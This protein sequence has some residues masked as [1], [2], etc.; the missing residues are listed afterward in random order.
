MATQLPGSKT[1]TVESLPEAATLDVP[2]ITSDVSPTQ[3]APQGTPTGERTFSLGTLTKRAPT[4]KKEPE[5]EPD[6]DVRLKAA[7]E[8]QLQGLKNKARLK[9]AQGNQLRQ[10]KKKAYFSELNAIKGGINSV[11]AD[12]LDFPGDATAVLLNALLDPVAPHE[13]GSN[14]E[15]LGRKLQD[16][17]N[18]IYDVFGLE[19]LTAEETG[20]DKGLPTGGFTAIAKL[21]IFPARDE[22]GST[23]GPLIP[24]PI[25]AFGNQGTQEQGR[26]HMGGRAIMEGVITSV[27]TP[28]LSLI[29]AVPKHGPLKTISKVKRFLK[30]IGD[31]SSSQPTLPVP[32]SAGK[33]GGFPKVQIRTDPKAINFAAREVV[34]SMGFAVGLDIGTR[35][36]PD[37]VLGQ[38]AFGAVQT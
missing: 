18:S 23:L 19:P 8:R 17:L 13:E 2:A 27:L 6:N 38:L 22:D 16:G 28:Q 29:K 25:K 1:A 26:F 30:K 37:S 9:E 21:P 5:K 3:G 33:F 4:T 32:E 24:D 7:Q 14:G 36:Y 34:A 20:L 10:L 12:V 31:L 35:A 11:V 15:F